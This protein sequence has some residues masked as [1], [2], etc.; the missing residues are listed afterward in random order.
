MM[1]VS[2]AIAEGYEFARD[3]EL[4][5]IK[6]VGPT[7]GSWKTW[8]G[9]K[10]DNVICHD[11]AKAQELIGRAF[12]AVCNFYI[13]KKYYQDLNRPVRVKLYDGDF[14]QE[15]NHAEDVISLHL[16]AAESD[17]VL[18]LGY[19]LGKL[20]PPADAY[21]KH[22]LVNYHGLIRS[23][24]NNNPNVQWV[25]IDHDGDLDKAYQNMPNLTCDTMD[26]VL[27]L[28]I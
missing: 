5:T 28:L 6:N 14:E 21:E 20:D 13:P 3:G 9:C 24:M 1:R 8:R 15:L 12:Q 26:N 27:K 11:R 7:W 2:W 25:L 10:T 22:K 18:L 23:T 16:A 19:Q 17:I 4:D